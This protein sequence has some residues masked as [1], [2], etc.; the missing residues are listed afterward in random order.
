MGLGLKI[1]YKKEK[2]NLTD[3]AIENQDEI[4]VSVI[5]LAEEKEYTA[6]PAPTPTAPVNW[7]E[8]LVALV[9]PAAL[10]GLAPI[11]ALTGLFMVLSAKDV[12]LSPAREQELIQ[13]YY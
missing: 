1:T 11:A 7:I 8:A 12:G 13:K 9:G 6:V 2:I 4:D 5:P 3:F 10:S